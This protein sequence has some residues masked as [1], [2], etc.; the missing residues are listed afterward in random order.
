MQTYKRLIN[1][2]AKQAAYNI[3]ET[4]HFS[5]FYIKSCARVSSQCEDLSIRGVRGDKIPLSSHIFAE[6]SKN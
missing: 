1:C 6:Q 4:S 2:P 3:F 5:A